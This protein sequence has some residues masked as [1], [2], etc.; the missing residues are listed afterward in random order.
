MAGLW[1]H[2]KAVYVALLLGA[3][4][5]IFNYIVCGGFT[6]DPFLRAIIFVLIAYIVGTIAEK[7]DTLYDVLKRS[8]EKLRQVYGSLEQRVKERTAELSNINE[9]LRSEILERERAEKA[10]RESE[11]KFKTLTESSPAAILLYREDGLIYAN[12]TAETITGY[13]HDE[14]LLGMTWKFVHPDNRDMIIERA[15][16]RLRGE[17]VPSRYEVKIITRSGD[18]RWFD[19]SADLISY[20]GVP[21]GLVSGIDITDRK[22]TEKA[23]IKSRAILSRAQSIAHVGNWAWDLKTQDIQWSDEIYRIF[24]HEPKYLKPTYAWLADNI[25]PDDR[26]LVSDSAEAAINE[27]RLFNIDFR[28]ITADGSVRYVNCVADKLR[29]DEKGRP[30]WMYGIMQDITARKQVEEALQDAKAQ[31]E[32]YLDLMGHDINN[33]N[34]IGIG[35]LEMALDTLKL[36]DRERQMIAKPLEALENSTRLISNVRKLQR[37]KDGRLMLHEM[38]IGETLSRLI[39]QY[40]RVPGRSITINYHADHECHV[41]ANDLLSDVFSNIIGNAVKHSKGPLVIDIC[42]K[43]AVIGDKLYCV[44]CIEDNGP[45]IPDDMKGQLFIGH[46][47][48]KVFTGSGLGLFLVKTLVEDFNGTVGVD[49]RVPGDFSRGCSF[50]VTLP[51]LIK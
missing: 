31:A 45:G 11:E 39:P 38:D 29:R 23:L 14:L 48:G 36:D 4:H 18:E 37:A 30:L 3:A 15:A 16:A 22:K 33:M 28:I 32:L 46:H 27:N 49:D 7:K 43:H 2:K 25:H 5:V 6:Y 9:A 20:G 51:A 47:R 24:G 35:F 13:T 17:P 50:T 40:S 1:Y 21:T 42:L 19:I 44:V 41:L 12:R 26:K 34:Q 10:A 8:D